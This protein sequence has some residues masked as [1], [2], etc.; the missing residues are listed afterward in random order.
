MVYVLMRDV[1]CGVI[2]DVVCCI[3]YHVFCSAMR[4][5]MRDVTVVCCYV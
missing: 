5:V 4:G 1:A 3:V 2:F